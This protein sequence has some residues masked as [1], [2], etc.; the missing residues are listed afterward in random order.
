MK[1][2]HLSNN[3]SFEA[4]VFSPFF[5]SGNGSKK[6]NKKQFITI[7]TCL[8][9]SFFAI[10][11]SYA[12]TSSTA[13]SA[14]E[15]KVSGKISD[16]YGGILGASVLLKGATIGVSCEEDGSFVFPNALKNGDVLV[17]SA[18]G[19]LPKE[20]VVQTTGTTSNFIVTSSLEM[21]NVIVVGALDNNVL[22]QSSSNLE[23]TDD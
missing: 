6:T 21:D 15:V 16:E 11:S 23:T 7:V 17:I 10:S 20:I 1:Q 12:Q 19:Y 4:K 14:K 8:F 3:S 9:L 22:F 2:L 18:M 13:D 5:S